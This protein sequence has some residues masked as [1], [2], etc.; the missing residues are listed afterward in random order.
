MVL[1]DAR[2]ERFYCDTCKTAWLTT[3]APSYDDRRL[4]WP[5]RESRTDVS[6]NLISGE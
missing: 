3:T 1:T 2:Q 5:I 6:G 4:L